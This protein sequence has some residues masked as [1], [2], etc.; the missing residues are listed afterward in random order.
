MVMDER[1]TSTDDRAQELESVSE[2][3]SAESLVAESPSEDSQQTTDDVRDEA[4]HI[5]SPGTDPLTA[6]SAV[7]STDEQPEPAGAEVEASLEAEL[8]ETVPSSAEETAIRI[9]SDEEQAA[10]EDAAEEPALAEVGADEIAVPA[11]NAETSSDED[12]E[13]EE[14]EDEAL[15]YMFQL[16]DW[17]VVHTYAGYENKVKA[18]LASRIQSMNMEDKIYE[19]V[20]PT[21]EVMELKAG[22]MQSVQKKVF[23]GYI[24]VRMELDDDSWYVVRNT[25]GVTGFVGPT[26]AKPVPLDPS[27]VAGILAPKAEERPRPQLEFEQGE[28]VSVVGGA[29]SGYSG[30]VSTIDVDKQRVT[31]LLDLFGR[32]TP[33]ELTF[34]QVTK[35]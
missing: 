8:G 27:E 22:K 24:L 18:N 26:G 9:E 11:T 14:E 34:E 10:E 35:L 3:E 6:E 4:A 17:Y 30:P 33:V 7:V 1:T 29:F 13:E 25:P 28:V 16:G 5:A 21:E 20:V 2:E 19:V 31:V 15:N 32:E 23:P 12:A